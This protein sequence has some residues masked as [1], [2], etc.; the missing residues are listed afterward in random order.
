M[1]AVH[2]VDYHDA[3]RMR[4]TAKERREEARGEYGEALEAAA[5]AK[6]NR[7]KARAVAW[8]TAAAEGGTQEAKKVRMEDLAADAEFAKDMADRDV[9]IAKEK[10]DG[11]EADRAM[12]KSLI[13]WSSKVATMGRFD[14]NP[15]P[16]P[17]MPA[18][19]VSGRS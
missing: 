3:S 11:E 2:P 15:V 12:A 10:I 9:K 17:R 4:D 7:A 16:A 6:R 8:A 1:T 14:P 13:D 19:P 18:N 5:E